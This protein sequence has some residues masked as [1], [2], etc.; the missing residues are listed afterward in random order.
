VVDVV[1]LQSGGICDGCGNTSVG[2]AG[3][4][5]VT[6]HRV[7]CVMGVVTLHRVNCVMGVV[8]LHQV[9]CVMCME[10]LHQR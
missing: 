3:V 4:D 9:N 1:T 7:N 8:T 5:V 2:W 6:L 10:M